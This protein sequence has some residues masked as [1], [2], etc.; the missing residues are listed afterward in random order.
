MSTQAEIRA[1]TDILRK[2]EAPVIVELGAYCGEDSEFMREACKNWHAVNVMVEPDHGNCEMIRK[3]RRG[4]KTVLIEAA[5]ADYTGMVDFYAGIDS[6]CERSGSG[7]IR[8][9]TEHLKLFP[10]IEFASPRPVMCWSLDHL[11]TS[12]TFCEIDMLW[13]DIQGAERDMIVGGGLTL[14][15]VRYLFIEAEHHELYEGQALRDELLTLLPQFKVIGEFD[16]NLLLEA[17]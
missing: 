11:F 12:M 6:T 4:V 16:Y 2:I 3:Y 10:Q 1:I 17:K 9:P 13:V 15:R 5:I 8:K 14:G 7:S